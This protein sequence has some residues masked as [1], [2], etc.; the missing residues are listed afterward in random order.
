M[1]TRHDEPRGVAAS[2]TAEDQGQAQPRV[3][4]P[5]DSLGPWIER[6]V[7]NEQ[8]YGSFDPDLLETHVHDRRGGTPFNGYFQN[9]GYFLH[10]AGDVAGSF[11]SPAAAAVHFLDQPLGHRATVV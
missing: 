7:A 3:G 6:R 8:R 2:K 1:R 9:E 4:R 5:Q 11:A 10:A